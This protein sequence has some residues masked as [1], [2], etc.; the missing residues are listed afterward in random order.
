MAK[1][2][3]R[4]RSRVQFGDFGALASAWPLVVIGVGLVGGAVYA[5]T[6]SGAEDDSS[7]AAAEAVAAAAAAQ[8]A[9]AATQA[10]AI[11]AAKAATA[12]AAQAATPPP[13]SYYNAQIKKWI[14]PAMALAVAKGSGAVVEKLGPP[15]TPGACVNAQYRLPDGK[16]SV[17]DIACNWFQ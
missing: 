17:M 9:A 15:Q 2:T 16:L 13:G 11:A 3:R 5:F 1:R 10:K 7:D 12:A 6:R 8:A 14:T 4:K